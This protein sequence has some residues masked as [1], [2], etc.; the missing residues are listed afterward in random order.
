MLKALM[1]NKR[2]VI[3]ISFILIL[4]FSSML[5]RVVFDNQIPVATIM[6]DD[7][8]A[9]TA[10]PP[11]SPWAHPPFGTDH[12]SRDL[13]IIILIGAK[14]TIGIALLIAFVRFLLSSMFG[15]FLQL[16]LPSFLRKS[17]P[18]FEGCYY[19][20][21]SI[22]AYLF[23]SFVLMED[24]YRDGFATTFSE[25][26]MYEI[27]VL[28]VI[29]I[30]IVLI[31]VSK[32]VAIL[33]KKEFV[34]SVK[35]IGGSRWHLLNVHLMPYLRPQLFLLFVRE[36]IQVLLLL[37]HL[38]ILNILFGGAQIKTDMFDKAVFVSLSSEWSGLIGS[39]FRFLYT[40]YYWIPLVPILCFTIAI[41]AFKLMVEGCEAVLQTQ[42][43]T[44]ERVSIAKQRIEKREN[45]SLTVKSDSFESLS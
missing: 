42:K 39:N 5:Y 22:L 31:N 41:L 19:F 33:Q 30:P 14:Y 18:W 26:V 38:G 32:E 16:Y 3:G 21:A 44:S 11:Y 29:G 13:F 4:L 28:I 1:K 7:N 37:A 10:K 15:I 25:R 36:V 8:G 9:I 34:D 6:T 45:A 12:V 27:I 20:P 40:S 23:F 2:F 17:K 24:G 43:V 35:V